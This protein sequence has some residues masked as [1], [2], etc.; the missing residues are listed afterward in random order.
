M[1]A[2][3]TIG[4]VFHPAEGDGS[5]SVTLTEA[6]QESSRS[7]ITEQRFSAVLSHKSHN[8]P[9]T[10][11]EPQ[12]KNTFKLKSVYKER[13]RQTVEES[14]DDSQLTLHPTDSEGVS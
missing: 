2:C 4:G 5:V 12:R 14:V 10:E 1:W 3:L 6:Q 7:F 13:E 8:A 9:V 11:R